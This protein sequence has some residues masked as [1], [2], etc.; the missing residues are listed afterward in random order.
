M[1]RKQGEPI[2]NNRPLPNPSA[3]R[4]NNPPGPGRSLPN[5]NAPGPGRGLPQTPP[6]TNNPPPTIN[7][8]PP[9]QNNAPKCKALY[10]YTAQENDELTLR[11]GDIITI[12]KE[13]PDW[14]E[15]EINGVV[16]VF[17]ANY[18]TKV[19]V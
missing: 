11:K 6:P 18:V 15:G 17:P 3:N 2:L 14:W 1:I 5:P 16:G 7:A 19:D 13:H 10:N 8:P 9:K 12:I 4:P